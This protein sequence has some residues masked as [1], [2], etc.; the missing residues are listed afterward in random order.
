MR[1]MTG[2]LAAS[3]ALV[4]GLALA[5][6]LE[7]DHA[8][9]RV[10][11]IPEARSDIKIEVVKA[12]DKLP[13]QI[14]TSGDRTVVKG[15]LE[16]RIRD[17]RG[18]PEAMIRVDGVGEVSYADLPQIVVHM[19]MKVDIHESGAVFG[20]LGRSD[21]AQVSHS[22]CGGWTIDNVAGALNVTSS[23]VGEIKMG[24]A[25][26]LMLHVSGA[27]HASAGAV[28]DGVD[29][30]LSGAGGVDIA[31]MAGPL[32]AQVSGTG[33]VLIGAGQ[34]KA[35]RATVSGVGSIDFRGQAESLQASV[36][37]VGSVRARSVTG[38]VSKSVT[39]IGKVTVGSPPAEPD[40]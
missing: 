31:S 24:S 39:G 37:G 18:R 27:S 16:R 32:T 13:L 3:A 26:S 1:F 15:G 22:S 2:L 21:S 23:G 33:G 8:A 12:N 40:R 38:P 35:M 30:R 4:P 11:V 34:I 36:S 7:I 25:G 28:R 10:T 20:T 19:P 6:T 17:C 9:V 5:A 14:S 29:V